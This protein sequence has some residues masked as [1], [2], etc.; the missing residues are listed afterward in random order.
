MLN[1]IISNNNAKS[2]FSD[3]RIS[4]NN[5]IKN[6]RYNS[7]KK[8]YNFFPYYNDYDKKL[9]FILNQIKN[10]NEQTYNIRRENM[11][12]ILAFKENIFVHNKNIIFHENK[13][14]PDD[15]AYNLKT[16]KKNKFHMSNFNINKIRPKS[17]NVQYKSNLKSIK[18]SSMNIQLFFDEEYFDIS[19][20]KN[21]K[22]NVDI[23]CALNNRKK[24]KSKQS[25]KSQKILMKNNTIN[26]NKNKSKKKGNKPFNLKL[27][28]KNRAQTFIKRSVIN[29]KENY[30]AYLPKVLIKDMKN[31]YNFFSYISTD[32][33]F[34]KNY[35]KSRNKNISINNKNCIKTNSN[36][37]IFNN[38]ILKSKIE[39]KYKTKNETDKIFEEVTKTKKIYQPIYLKMS[40]IIKK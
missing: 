17:A 33:D 3:I 29:L 34:D 4:K 19:Y 10:L 1:H 8:P 37:N 12:K 5:K 23:R 27:R 15:M 26:A 35:K 7:Y 16:T 25:N 40:D 31:K 22:A 13:K 2:M 28:K 38:L 14:N 9:T 6:L 30:L 18:S 11:K 20:I 39:K 36:S 32:D 21:K 24:A